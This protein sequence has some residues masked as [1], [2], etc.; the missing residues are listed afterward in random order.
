[1]FIRKTKSR[2]S[3]CFQ[4]GRKQYGK[5]VL[6]KHVGCASRPEAIEM[7][8]IKAEEILTEFAFKDQLSLFPGTTHVP[9][10]KLVSWRITGYHQV[11]GSVYTAIGFPNTLLRDLVVARI[12]YPKSKIATIRYARDTLGITFSKDKVYRFLDTLDKEKLTRIAFDFVSKKNNGISLFFYDVTTLYFET[13]E[14]DD[15]RRKG[16]SKDHRSDV[17]Q[18]LIGLFVDTD[19]YPFDFD[20]FEGNT[21][22][23]HTF[24]TAIDA[25][26]KC[27]A[28]AALTVVADAGMLSENN[29]DYLR[30]KHISYIVGARLK[31]MSGAVVKRMI[32]HNFLTHPIL[33]IVAKQERLIIDYSEKRAKRDAQ[34]RER[35]IKK[36]EARLQKGEHVIRKSKY[37]LLKNQGTITGIDTKKVK[38][39]TQ[40]DGLKGYITNPNNDTAS[41]DIIKQYHNLWNVEKAFRMS[42]SDLRERP[43]YHRKL[44]RIKS[45]LILCFVSLLVLKETEVRLKPI[46]YSLAKAI[47]ILGKV[48][49]G[50]VRVGT[51]LL[52]VDSELSDEVEEIFNLFKGH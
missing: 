49:E 21:F 32:T 10:A 27:Y 17:P 16:F 39:D 36:L 48:G 13:E 8:R 26:T 23:G 28:F 44:I 45:H 14:E 4:I 18:I 38:E 31:N 42:K 33:E 12:V 3:T 9:R 41:E 30:E 24:Q 47:E 40:Y 29:L 46:G 22:E 7:L 51:I 52:D 25:I 37:I 6:V 11:F 35:L 15:F 5:F 20:F 19:G 34:V 1:M 2:N 50:K 43:I